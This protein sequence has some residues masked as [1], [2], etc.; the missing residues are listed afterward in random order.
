MVKTPGTLKTL[1]VIP[2]RYGSMRLPGKPLIDIAGKP[3]IQ[4]VYERAAQAQKIDRVLVATDDGRI[5]SAVESFGGEAVMSPPSLPTGT[6]R[7]ARVLDDLHLEHDVVFNLQGDEPLIDPVDLDRMINCFEQSPE[8]EMVSLMAQL[9][10]EDDVLNPN[11]VKVVVDTNNRALYFSRNPIP[12]W[13]RKE[14]TDWAQRPANY[15]LHLGVYAFRRDIV[16]QYA[17]WPRSP[18]E[19]SESLEQ[20]RALEHGVRI[21]MVT[22]PHPW[23]GVNT[24][25]DVERVRAAFLKMAEDGGTP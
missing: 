25:D 20:L 23:P 16:Q 15:W 22:T 18:L 24:P 9:H 4:R 17:C 6:D 14:D 19:R 1:C 21:T 8:T 7:V 5:K 10:S 12:Y 3:L 11:Q 13:R 2:S